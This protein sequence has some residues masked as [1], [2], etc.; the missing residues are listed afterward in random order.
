MQPTGP[1][2]CIKVFISYAHE[3]LELHEKLR[4][5]LRP[6]ERSGKMTIWRDQEI[7]AGANWEETI[8]THLDEADIILLLISSDFINS[9]YCW[10]KE[11]KKR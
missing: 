3:D 2:I 8:N 1:E 10:S 6:L 5:H 4:R 9:D 7:P 11:V